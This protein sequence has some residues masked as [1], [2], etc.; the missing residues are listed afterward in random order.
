MPW[1][2]AY[3][4]PLETGR[5]GRRVKLATGDQRQEGSREMLDH[6]CFTLGQEG[7]G[8]QA[9]GGSVSLPLDALWNGVAGDG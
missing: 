4:T 9:Q 7:E 6:D 2:L 1:G 3:L 5:Q 8:A